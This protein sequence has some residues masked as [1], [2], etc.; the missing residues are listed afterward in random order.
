MKFS[1]RH[2]ILLVGIAMVVLSFMFFSRLN[3]IYEKMLLG[4]L[5]F[6][7]IGY[8]LILFKDKLL[9][10]KIFWTIVLICGVVIQSLTEGPLI[11]RS[12]SDFISN[13]VN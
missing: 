3:S 7:I 4:G 8:I 9:K 6:V 5:C 11:K 13:W 1:F 10:Q 12:Y 2:I